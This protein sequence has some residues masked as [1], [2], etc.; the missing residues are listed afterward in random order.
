MQIMCYWEQGGKYAVLVRHVNSGPDIAPRTRLNST[1]GF[2]Q[3]GGISATI[4][5]LK[6]HVMVTAAITGE[7]SIN[8]VRDKKIE[9]V[10][11]EFGRVPRRPRAAYSKTTGFPKRNHVAWEARFNAMLADA[12][13]HVHK[14]NEK[15]RRNEAKG[16]RQEAGAG[17]G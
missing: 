16:L 1:F 10:V 8:S 7:F 3:K 9:C 4:V 2:Y 12:R 6:Q 17:A 11:E 5:K 13:L 15:E 14:L